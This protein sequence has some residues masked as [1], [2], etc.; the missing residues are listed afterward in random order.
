MCNVAQS[1]ID[2]GMEQGIERGELVMLQKL[3]TNGRISIEE[4]ALEMN[5]TVDRL[6]ELFET[7]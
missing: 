6:K 1:Y 4:A 5:V 3:V 7:L 2:K